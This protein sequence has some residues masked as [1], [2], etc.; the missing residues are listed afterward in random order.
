MLA[1]SPPV[2]SVSWQ[3][4]RYNITEGLELPICAEVESGFLDRDV[5][6]SISV[7]PDTAQGQ[8]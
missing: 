7:T 1:I 8:F 6:L 2:I 5:S 4:A 3:E